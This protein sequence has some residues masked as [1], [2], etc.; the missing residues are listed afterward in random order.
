LFFNVFVYN[1]PQ[2]L[3]PEGRPIN[4]FPPTGNV[5]WTRITTKLA[6]HTIF[7][8][9]DKRLEES[10]IVFFG[11][12]FSE[13]VQEVPYKLLFFLF[14]LRARQA[15][16]D[17]AIEGTIVLLFLFLCQSFEGGLLDRFVKNVWKRHQIRA[18]DLDQGVIRTVDVFY[19]LTY[20]H[21][22]TCF[23]LERSLRMQALS[24]LG[25]A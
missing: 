12:Q 6:L 4:L 2:Q 19:F 24:R 25:Q 10:P 9:V 5:D 18:F 8:R 16:G 21:L 7:K 22:L 20:T 23:F 13:T 11:K 14:V 3:W 1:P 17:E 15:D